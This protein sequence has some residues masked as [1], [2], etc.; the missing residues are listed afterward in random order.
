VND[1]PALLDSDTTS[2]LARGHANVVRRAREYLEAHGRFTLSAV[3]VFERLRG[4]R[5]ALRSGK[6]FEDHLRQFQ[7][8]SASSVVLPVDHRVADV[9]AT[10]WAALSGHRRA[11]VGDILIA[12]TAQ[13]NDLSLVTRNR[14][15]FQPM[16]TIVGIVL[17]DWSR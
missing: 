10:I 4:Y 14:R 13:A 17:V 12:P 6:R 9:A 15:D 11:S 3:T 7:A 8:F 2:D 16:A 1:A 5:A